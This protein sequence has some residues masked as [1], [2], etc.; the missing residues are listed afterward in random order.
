M[1]YIN[2]LLSSLLLASFVFNSCTLERKDANESEVTSVINCETITN[3]NAD[4]CLRMNQ[5]QV[6]G[7]HN[8]YKLYPHPDLVERLNEFVPGWAENINYEHRP[9]REQLGE[10]KMRQLEIDIFADPDG[11]LYAEPAGALL[12]DDEE[13]I[14]HPELLEPGL[15]VLHV[16]DTDYRTTCLTFKSC[17]TEVKDWSL[18]NPTHLPIM[19]LVEVKQRRPENR[20]SLI[21]TEPV[22]FDEELMLEIDEEIWSIFSREN[23]IIPDDVRGDHE[24]LIKGVVENGWPTL[25]ESR[26]KVFFALDNTD[27]ARDIYLSGAPALEGRALFVSSPPGEP[28]SA[29]IKMN[30]AIGTFD[31]IQENVAAG[32]LIRSRSDT[33]VHE[34]KTGDTTRLTAS[35]ASG[36]QYIS[37]DYPEPSPFGSGFVAEFPDTD[38]PGRCNPVSAPPGCQNHFITE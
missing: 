31:R 35:L 37:T 14:R 6:F 1:Q 5:I 10:L 26:G 22:Q 30:D 38:G 7:T 18:D 11:G 13:F 12:I 9:I 36:A 16:Q 17:L 33:P 3:E 28:S 21:F 34:A 15:K 29:F 24:S 20:G 4:N 19:I 2:S 23:V 8:S 25:G 27:S 32:H